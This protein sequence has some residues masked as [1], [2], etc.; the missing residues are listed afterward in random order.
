MGSQWSFDVTWEGMGLFWVSTGT[1]WVCAEWRG[2]RRDLH[3]F[4]SFILDTILD[5]IIFY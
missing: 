3:V 2:S 5:S 4:T 1:G